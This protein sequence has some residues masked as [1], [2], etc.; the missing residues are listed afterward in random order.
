MILKQK[1]ECLR[2]LFDKFALTRPR[3]EFTNIKSLSLMEFKDMMFRYDLF[4]DR[5]FMERDANIAYN[6]SMIGQI[7]ELN[8]DRH[9]SMSFMEF[10]ECFARCA[11]KLSVENIY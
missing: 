11:E 7:D 9:I 8:S 1:I 10:L 6:S 3:R 4:D 5:T 2:L